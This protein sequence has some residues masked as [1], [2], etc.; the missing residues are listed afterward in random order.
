M[1]SQ[2]N[3]Y[4]SNH[5]IHNIDSLRKKLCM[6]IYKDAENVWHSFN[7]HLWFFKSIQLIRTRREL[8]QPNKD[9]LWK[10]HIPNLYLMM[11]DWMIFF[12]H[13]YPGTRQGIHTYHF[14]TS[15]HVEGLANAVMH[16]KE[17]KIDKIGEEK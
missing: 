1:R 11:K 15:Y 7:S 14:Y 2:F 8:P 6:I 9:H 17:I 13:L 12:T 16:R 4:N 5:A 3:I 10:K